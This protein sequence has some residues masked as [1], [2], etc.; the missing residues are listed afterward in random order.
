MFHV[1][2]LIAVPGLDA[3]RCLVWMRPRADTLTVAA[4]AP[5]T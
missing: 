5:A 4:R 1:E 3:E 2:P